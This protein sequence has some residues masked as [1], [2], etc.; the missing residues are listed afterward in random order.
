MK[1]LGEK[2]CAKFVAQK[3][4]VNVNFEK[5]R[6]RTKRNWFLQPDL[7]DIPLYGVLEKR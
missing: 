7:L 6:S 5:M 3:A 4:G 1:M 2:L